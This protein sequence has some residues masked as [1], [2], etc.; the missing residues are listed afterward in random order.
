MFSARH[1]PGN[2]ILLLFVVGLVSVLLF[3][4]CGESP[5][6]TSD[7]T[8]EPISEPATQLTDQEIIYFPVMKRIPE[9]S[10]LESFEGKLVVKDGFIRAVEL[11]TGES[12]LVIWPP[13]F[14]LDISHHTAQIQNDKGQLVAQVGDN[15]I[16]GDGGPDYECW[17]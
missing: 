7:P 12:V 8:T 1:K 4:G 2:R 5:E 14:S 9:T 13:G 10:L 11:E 15:V 3:S 16:L 6:K 17:I